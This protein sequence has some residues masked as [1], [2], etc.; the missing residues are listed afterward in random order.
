M[1]CEF[2]DASDDAGEEDFGEQDSLKM[3]GGQEEV[4]PRQG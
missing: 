4:A 1:S 3:P 2:S